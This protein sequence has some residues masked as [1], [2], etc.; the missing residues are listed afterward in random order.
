MRI[1]ECLQQ[2]RGR[3]PALD[4][5]VLLAH[6]LGRTRSHLH[7]RPDMPVADADAAAYR[8][9]VEQ[10]ATGTP[11]AYLVGE[12]EFWSLPL[13]VSPAVLIPRPETELLVELALSRLA[14]QS[15][16][17][18]LGTGSGAIA[19]ALAH[20]RPD[21]KI[22]ASDL[23]PAA[24]SVAATNACRL[25]LRVDF[26]CCRWFAGLRARFDVIVSNPPYV[27]AND[28]H[29]AAPSLAAEP[30]LALVAGADGLAAL[31]TIVAGAGA[32]LHDGGWLILEHGAA[33]GAA[34]R[35]LLAHAGFTGIATERDLAGHERATLAR[36]RDTR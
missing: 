18:D 4:A 3:L 20:D 36:W 29:L 2:A 23:S 9:L 1:A 30:A 34:V 10:R 8:H 7:A 19:L 11:L 28:P 5:E 15:S 35:D 24:L 12:R 17:L 22:Y 27:A 14:P 26:V 33:Q 31:R 25:A 16:V 13:A 32:R 6:V 21:C